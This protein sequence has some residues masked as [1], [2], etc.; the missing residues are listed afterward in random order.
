MLLDSDFPII[1]NMTDLAIFYDL[2]TSDQN[3]IG[4][5]LNFSFI[6]VDKDFKI[7][8]EFSDDILISRLQ[9]PSP[10]AILANRVDV[11]EHQKTAKLSEKMAALKIAQFIDKQI[12]MYGRASLIGYNSSKFDLPFLRTTLIRNGINPYFFGKLNYR[13]LLL[14]SRKLSVSVKDFPRF[15]GKTNDRISLSLE[16]LTNYFGL[17]EGKQV[18]S[19]R[20]DVMITIELAKLYKEK[21][22]FDVRT[23][24][25]Y[26]ANTL[27]ASARQGKVYRQYFPNYDL[28]A[29]SGTTAFNVEAACTLL[30]ADHKYSLWID[31]ERYVQG[32]GRKS[33]SWYSQ[34]TS[35][36]F[37]DKK[38]LD[39]L[40]L[41][42]TAKKALQEFK[43][44][45]LKNYFGK[46]TCDIEQDIYR[47][48]ISMINNLNDVIWQSDKN[49][50][51]SRFTKE[52]KII[53]LRHELANYAWGNK[54][55]K[56]VEDMLRQYG[57]YRYGGKMPINKFKDTD[58]DGMEMGDTYHIGLKELFQAAESPEC[59]SNADDKRLMQSLKQFYLNSDIYR[60]CSQELEKAA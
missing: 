17:L 34:Q 7:V 57:T 23:Y 44:I 51:K 54:S 56:A 41:R 25:A 42:E 24:E 18:H 2:E 53:H 11:L 59:N 19:S 3:P 29:V 1:W 46:S 5:I 32:M 39:S 35:S 31:L 15:A 27:H 48:D 50:S 43:S 40:E 49:G 37:T 9:L 30:D 36:F 16:T 8:D 4:Q 60:I 22:G 52:A 10:Q 45:N 38:E 14:L 55:D 13:D 12:G 28:A 47:L 58:Q 21:F 26:E 20:E 6:C 33:I